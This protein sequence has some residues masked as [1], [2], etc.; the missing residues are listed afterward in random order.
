M[1][2]LFRMT[3]RTPQRKFMEIIFQLGRI[4][5]Y[6]LKLDAVT[7]ICWHVFPLFFHI[8]P[9]KYVLQQ[10]STK[11]QG[12]TFTFKNRHFPAAAQDSVWHSVGV[13]FPS[14]SGTYEGM[15]MSY[16]VMM[17]HVCE[18]NPFFDACHDV[19]IQAIS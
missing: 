9:I 19:S 1:Q 6:I 17:C 7:I 11:Y 4:T 3:R 10:V 13:F 15:F 5:V 2:V 18:S 16:H 8:F 12:Q 14:L